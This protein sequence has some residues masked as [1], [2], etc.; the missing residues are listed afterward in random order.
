ML[1]RDINKK[2]VIPMKITHEKLTGSFEEKK[3]L[4]SQFNLMDDDFCSVVLENKE[5]CEYVIHKLTGKEDLKILNNKTQES[6][7]NYL[8]HSC[9]LDCLAEDSNHTLYDIEVQ[10]ENSDDQ[11]KRMRYYRSAIDFTK[12]SKGQ[13]YKNMPEVYTIMITGFDPF[14]L[15]KVVYESE[16]KVKGTDYVIDD[17]VHEM[18]FNN[19]VNDGSEIAELLQYFKNSNAGNTNFGALS[20]AVNYHKETEKGVVS[21]CQ[22]VEDYGYTMRNEGI[23]EG[24]AKI[25][26]S[27]IETGMSVEEIAKATK[28][29]VEEVKKLSEK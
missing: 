19:T 17:G 21:V 14:G 28:I 23:K 4:V 1:K 18:Y 22:A 5:A 12:F 24:E 3:E 9:V 13:P 11:I 10:V 6:I 26:K 29:S 2:K 15:G 16:K 25:I 8:G 7:K 20:D 27:L